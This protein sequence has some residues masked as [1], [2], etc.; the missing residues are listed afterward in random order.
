MARISIE[1]RNARE[2]QLRKDM[3]RCFFSNDS[4]EYCIANAKGATLSFAEEFFHREAVRRDASKTATMIKNA[5][6][7]NMKS[8][9]DY[10]FSEVKLPEPLTPDNLKAL[11]FMKS[12]NSLIMHGICGSGKTMLS[13]CLGIL[14]CNSGYKVK[15]YTLSQLA[16]KLRQA[17]EE[18]RIETMLD[19]LASLDLLI[20][21]EWGY[22]KVDR[23]SA[24]LIYRVIADSYERKSL[25]ITT[26]LPFSEWGTLFSDEQLAAAIIDRIVHYGYSIDTGKKDWR[27]ANSPMNNLQFT[28]RIDDGR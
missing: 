26:N 9:E 15:F 7:P 8:F 17:K 18:E 4:Y 1:A 5:G 27:L 12:K 11:D 2:E 16:M 22:T 28:R 14:A 24:N 10:D 21:D 19:M 3:R 13:I 6:F 23:E 20:I 25:I